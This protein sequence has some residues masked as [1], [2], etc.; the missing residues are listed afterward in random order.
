MRYV[1][2]KARNAFIPPFEEGFLQQLMERAVNDSVKKYVKSNIKKWLINDYEPVKPIKLRDLN[3]PLFL[4][5]QKA[6]DW[7]VQGVEKGDTIYAIRIHVHDKERLIH[8]IDYLNTLHGDISRIPVKELP[9][10]VK[11]WEKTFNKSFEIEDGIEIIHRYSNGFSWVKVFGKDS[12]NREGKLMNHCVGG[13]YNQVK[14]NKCEIY[15]LRDKN[16]KPHI[17]I[18]Y[19][20]K[21]RLVYQI[22]G[23]SNTPPKEIYIKYLLHFINKILKP[24]KCNNR[25]LT[26]LG[27]FFNKKMYKLQDV[28]KGTKI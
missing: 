12:L 10:L 9:R 3:N 27:Y 1:E 18:E 7:L 8:Y 14:E 6:P 11:E 15:S 16:N 23:N 24:L 5:G 26:K 21:Q 28:P 20:H 2:I 22:K 13:Y 19:Q 25:E 17:T 4:R